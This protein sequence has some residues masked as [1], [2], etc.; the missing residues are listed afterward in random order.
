MGLQQPKIATIE[1]F[2]GQERAVIL[3]STVRSTEALLDEDRKHTLGFVNNPKRLN[4]ALTRA[5][6]AVILFCN[7]HLLCKDNFWNQVI[8]H[9]VKEDKYMGCDLPDDFCDNNIDK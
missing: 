9:A 3:L 6:V 7:P 4:V 1:E 5:Q 8:T 2:Q